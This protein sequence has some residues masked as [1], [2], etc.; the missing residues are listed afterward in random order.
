M[1]AVYTADDKRG[2][3]FGVIRVPGLW[4]YVRMQT[5]IIRWVAA[6]AVVCIAL[7][8]LSSCWYTKQAGYFLAERIRAVPVTS[9]EGKKDTLPQVRDMIARVEAVRSF[10]VSTVG[11]KPTKNYTRYVAVDKDYVADVVSA[12][13]SDSF[14]RYAW[15]YPLLG[16]LPYKGF[17]E[18]ADAE[19]EKDRLKAAG[20]D[21][22]VRQVDAF[23]SLGFFTDPLYSFMAHYDEDVLADMIIHESAHATLFIKGADQFNEEFATFIGRFGADLYMEQHYGKD[24]PEYK[25]RLDRRHDGD[26]FVAFLKETARQLDAVYADASI[27]RAE[28]LDRK[29][30]II[31][32]RAAIFKDEAARLFV[33][34]GYRDFDMG[35]I[36]N[37]YIDLYRLYEDDLDLYQRWFDVVAQGSL[38]RFVESLV[39]LARVSGASIKSAMAKQLDAAAN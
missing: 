33:E 23:S 28:K 8:S 9:L 20:L 39:A 2:K 31:K 21:V 14:N 15:H 25:H 12:C 26:A 36:N 13:A 10:A 11:L 35:R 29:A 19:R 4:Y 37:A 17:Y 6:T 1:P 27:Q 5:N 24:S 18:K 34:Q 7:F 38:P 30:Q 3:A 16:A 32:E 22:I